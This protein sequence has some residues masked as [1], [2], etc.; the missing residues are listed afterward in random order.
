MTQYES[1]NG[2]KTGCFSSSFWSTMWFTSKFQEIKCQKE[3]LWKLLTQVSRWPV[4]DD[5]L[6]SS[7]LDNPSAGCVNGAEGTLVMKERGEFRFKLSDLET[8]QYFAYDVQLTGA[9]SHWYWE[10][11]QKDQTVNL[12]MGVV[13]S[14]WAAPLYRP[15]IEKECNEAF[16]HALLNLKQILEK[17]KPEMKSVVA[18]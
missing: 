3:D 8:N 9:S 1:V 7:E 6:I 11:S 13:L 4:W 12:E 5:G 15:F 16:D 18:R 14:G 2:R 17:T 10:W